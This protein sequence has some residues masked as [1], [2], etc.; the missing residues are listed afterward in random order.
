ME[1][2]NSSAP[3]LG[4]SWFPGHMRKAMRQLDEHLDLAD[5]VLLVMDAR[6]PASSRQPELEEM[7]KKRQKETIIV[8]NKSDL[9]DEAETKRWLAWFKAQNTAAVA[10]RSVN[11]KGA[12]PLE[13]AIA[14]VRRKVQEKRR[15][16][17]LRPRDPRL[18]VAGIP[19][20]GKSSLLNRLAGSVRAKTGARPGVTRGNQW[21]GVPGCWQILDSPGI[22]YPRIDNENI[23]TALAAASCVKHDAIPLELVGAKLLQKLLILGKTDGLLDESLKKARKETA[24]SAPAEELLAEF[25]RSKGFYL[26]GQE[27]DLIRGS[28]FVLKAFAQ[29][30]IGRVTLEK[31]P[32][33][34]DPAA[35]EAKTPDASEAPPA[36]AAPADSRTAAAAGSQTSASAS[37][38]TAPPPTA[39]R[40]T[41]LASLASR[42]SDGGR[43]R[44]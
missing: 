21:V 36:A 22:L 44:R 42:S 24:A 37:S 26:N 12:G 18:I 41:T 7:L 32:A 39:K 9:A 27:P 28:R 19:N 14:Q 8:L 29:G 2:E 20:V 15:A 16:K 11:G 31:A 1:E 4:Y 13:S 33:L 25:C 38:K 3:T 35:S 5:I 10:M 23:L 30:E 17:G 6:I 34:P 40:R 43:R